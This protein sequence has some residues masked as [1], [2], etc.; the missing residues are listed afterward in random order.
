MRTLAGLTLVL[1]MATSARAAETNRAAAPVDYELRVKDRPIIQRGF[2]PESSPRSIAVGLPGGLSYCF[3]AESCRLRYAWSGG[4][5]DMKP[6]WHGR[7][8]SPPA[9]RG[10]KF[11][12]APDTMTL[13]LGNRTAAPKVQFLG[14]ALVNQAPEFR[15]TVEGVTVRERIEAAPGGGLRCVFEW[16][17]PEGE[18][19]FHPPKGVRVSAAG[20]D[21]KADAGGWVTIPPGAPRR[22]EVSIPGPAGAGPVKTAATTTNER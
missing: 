1:L 16:A 15:F 18:L 5:L 10:A 21:L 7:G 6:T 9:L 12:V 19:N 13:S 3:D 4:F 8:A 2:L 20:R 22:F 17:G 11:F 14:Y